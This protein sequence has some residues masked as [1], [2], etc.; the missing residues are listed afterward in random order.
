MGEI[1]NVEVTVQEQYSKHIISRWHRPICRIVGNYR[2]YFICMETN[3]KICSKL[4]SI[5]DFIPFN[6]A[7]VKS[8]EKS[9]E[10]HMQICS[11]NNLLC[12][13]LTL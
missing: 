7:G 8:K 1:L 12:V 11:G 4:I 3:C 2:Y 10:L 6:V 5:G 9:A 13:Y